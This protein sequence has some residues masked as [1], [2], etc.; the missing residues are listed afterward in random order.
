MPGGS[1]DYDFRVPDAGLYW[2]HPHIDSA[3]QVTEGLYGTLLV[4]DPSEP[5][6]FGDEVVLVFSD[7]DSPDAGQVVPPS[8]DHLVHL[9]GGEGNAI[10]VNGRVKP[11]LLAR[12][13]LRQRWRIL[14]AARSRF[15]QLSLPGHKFVRIG[16]DGG[17]IE[18][19]VESDML[20][21]APGERADV[22]MV[23]AGQPGSD[24]VMR[25][26]PYDRGYGTAFARQ[27]EDV[28]T[29]HFDAA[30]AVAPAPL[31]EHLRTI[32]P[33]DTS[34][35]TQ[36]NIV[37]TVTPAD[38]GVDGGGGLEVNG[39][40]FD[41]MVM[42]KVG[43]TSIWTVD[44]RTDWDHPWHLHGFF[45]QP[46]DAAGQPVHEWKDT[47]N[48]PTKKTKSFVVRYEDRPGDWMFHC[49]ILEHAELGM[50]GMLMLRP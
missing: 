17:L 30:P 13:G 49:H 25:W 24:V 11:R 41:T 37:L 15:F 2:Y 34:S 9:F 47:F 27:P 12:K 35:A 8:D 18:T 19:P 10:L 40:M 33:I 3:V 14:N 44:N 43:E 26:I 22:S 5:R 7:I 31:P 6:D 46:I 23:P 29:V 1:F 4:E 20:L 42:A 38:A 48:V 21:V 50:M 45:F 32:A 16:G 39:K 28:M 36:T